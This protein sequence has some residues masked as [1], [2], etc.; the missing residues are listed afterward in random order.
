MEVVTDLFFHTL[1][2]KHVIKN[3]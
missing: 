3:L 2:V 1:K